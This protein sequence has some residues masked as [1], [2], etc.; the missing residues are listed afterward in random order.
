MHDNQLEDNEVIQH[1]QEWLNAH[2]SPSYSF[3]KKMADTDSVESRD[4]LMELADQYNILYDQSTTL[5]DLVEKIR[6]AMNLGN[7]AV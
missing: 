3:L 4:S 1:S 6:L 7:E 2:G 5:R